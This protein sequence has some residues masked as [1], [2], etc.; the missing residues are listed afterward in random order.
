MSHDQLSYDHHRHRGNHQNLHTTNGIAVAS[1][2]NHVVGKLHAAQS[3][4]RAT[5]YESRSAQIEIGENDDSIGP[6]AVAFPDSP[7]RRQHHRNHSDTNDNIVG[8]FPGQQRQTTNLIGPSASIPDHMGSARQP[9]NEF[10]LE[11]PDGA[12][13]SKSYD[14]TTVQ[15]DRRKK[16]TP[17]QLSN[18]ELLT[19]RPTLIHD[20]GGEEEEERYEERFVGETDMSLSQ[21]ETVS[22]IDAK[23]H[24]MVRKRKVS[25]GTG[26]TPKT[27]VLP[28]KESMKEVMNLAPERKKKTSRTEA[29]RSERNSVHGVPWETPGRVAVATPELEQAESARRERDANLKRKLD[30]RKQKTA[31][32]DVRIQLVGYRRVG[33]FS[34]S[35]P[36]PEEGEASHVGIRQ[37]SSLNFASSS[38]VPPHSHGRQGESKETISTSSSFEFRSAFSPTHTRVSP[39]QGVIEFGTPTGGPVSGGPPSQAT[40]KRLAAMASVPMAT[41]SLGTSEDRTV[42]RANLEETHLSDVAVFGGHFDP[43]QLTQERMELN[44]GDISTVGLNQPS[45]LATKKERGKEDRAKEKERAREKERGRER[46]REFASGSL[47][48]ER[49]GFRSKSESVSPKRKEGLEREGEREK[50]ASWEMELSA[51][52]SKHSSVLSTP[53]RY[54]MGRVSR[55]L[56]E[57]IAEDNDVFADDLTKGSMPD[58]YHHSNPVSPAHRRTRGVKE[59]TPDSGISDEEK[60]KKKRS[61][62]YSLGRKLSSSM[63]ELF[64]KEKKINPTSGTTWHFEVGG[65]DLYP[66]PSEPQLSVL[67]ENERRE[68]LEGTEV[69]PRTTSTE[70]V[71]S[72]QQFREQQQSSPAVTGS[73]GRGNPLA[74]LFIPPPGVSVK[75]GVTEATNPKQTTPTGFYE[76]RSVDIE[77]PRSPWKSVTSDNESA[78][79]EEGYVK[80]AVNIITTSPPPGASSP[81]ETTSSKTI[82]TSSLTGA[83]G[84]QTGVT[85]SQTG[86][87]TIKER[88]PPIRTDS[89]IS[90]EM[91]HSE[92]APVVKTLEGIVDTKSPKK[93]PVSK[94]TS[95][96]VT[97]KKVDTKEKKPLFRFTKSRT[98]VQRRTPSPRPRSPVSVPGSASG[99]PQSSGRFG[100]KSSTSAT[101]SKLKNPESAKPGSTKI[102][103]G[104]TKTG[105][106]SGSFRGSQISAVPPGGR[107]SPSSRGSP[108]G[109]FRGGARSPLQS[110]IRST[111]S[112]TVSPISPGGQNSGRG[113]GSPAPGGSARSPRGS[114]QGGSPKGSGRGSKISPP[115]GSPGV[116][117]PS[118]RTSTQLNVT[119][120]LS[121]VVTRKH[122]PS[123]S[124]NAALKGKRRLSEPVVS[125]LLGTSPFSRSPSER[126]SNVSMGNAPKPVRKAPPP[127][128]KATQKTSTTNQSLSRT[129][130]QTSAAGGGYSSSSSTS[131]PRQRKKGVSLS[132][133][134]LSPKKLSTTQLEK[135]A[136]V[137]T[138]NGDAVATTTTKEEAADDTEKLMSSIREKLAALSENSQ[139]EDP[140]P[141]DQQYLFE[142][143]PPP[144][145][146]RPLP[147]P[148]LQ[149]APKP[150]SPLT[151]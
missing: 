136:A 127:P 144:M 71:L 128:I 19:Y 95:V 122:P 11:E 49:G 102:G 82:L 42:Y 34:T 72:G 100:T 74:H 133:S 96:T 142:V 149:P 9:R 55:V 119:R 111:T 63:R 53:S 125:P 24:E 129:S 88:S 90:Y 59:G 150:R 126:R 83:T 28:T 73:I 69:V 141:L 26:R 114:I 17:R 3:M 31:K 30:R 81:R 92:S 36:I 99:S 18:V 89:V 123:V 5:E 121:P 110:S 94:T 50:L 45:P 27:N 1:T 91:P 146:P 65:S 117:S 87:P 139:S 84:S 20:T 108:I 32:A 44:V 75:K 130:S 4:D 21:Q 109:S 78:D 68:I 77:E 39:N 16:E 120:K 60:P 25:Q 40:K 76:E 112:A 48:I 116:K 61:I 37:S 147:C 86:L 135:D 67:T 6:V 113:R 85:G 70:V 54:R 62:G 97:T 148:F 143:P 140:N 12:S 101:A 7:P 35:P 41:T 79:S 10:Y 58:I 132:H 118:P 29:R 33:E 98:V 51:H 103:V 80:S 13:A 145:K 134:P 93:G 64:S 138:G 23:I 137:A 46:G 47:K 2:T 105:S 57:P 56:E 104:G 43:S 15:S 107:M 52:A 131:S 22:E 124:A 66:A 8:V 38:P 151:N 106:P 115:S 14:V